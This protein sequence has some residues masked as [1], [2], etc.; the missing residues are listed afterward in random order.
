MSSVIVLKNIGKCKA[1]GFIPHFVFFCVGTLMAS[2][3]VRLKV[4]LISPM[5][6]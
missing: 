6:M 2:N 4:L 3:D 5:Y 1:I